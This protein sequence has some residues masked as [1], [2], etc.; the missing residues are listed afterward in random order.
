MIRG[1]H[2][3]KAMYTGTL[4]TAKKKVVIGDDDNAVA[5]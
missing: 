4:M 2:E 5:D 1:R 3:V